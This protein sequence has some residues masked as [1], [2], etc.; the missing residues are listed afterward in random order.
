MKVPKTGPIQKAYG[1][2]TRR[3]PEGTATAAPSR[4]PE[5]VASIMGISEAELTP[6]VRSAMMVLMEEVDTLRRELS[7]AKGRI[8]ELAALADQDPLLPEV[9]N[10]RAFVREM[11]RTMSFAERY[12][13]EAS[14][15][16]F[17]LNNFK[18]INDT[19]GHAA[20]DDVLRTVGEILLKNVRDSD[21][22]GRLGGDEF[23][24]VLAKADQ[25]NALA[26]AESLATQIHSAT[27]SITGGEKIAISSSFGAY[28]F[29]KGIDAKSAMDEADKA[30]FQSKREHKSKT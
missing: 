9:L 7:L 11:S 25:K 21:V 24:V 6:Q 5:D 30:M 26:K 28:T 27:I 29:Q 20:G 23:G 3:K 1:V 10:R 22:V 2:G 8:E 15:I 18:T 14:L 16:Y 4:S 17:D 13:M 12:D 19:H